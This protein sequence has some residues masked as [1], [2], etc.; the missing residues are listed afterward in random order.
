MAKDSTKRYYWL[1]LKENFFEDDTIQFIEEQ[2][3]GKDYVIF[4]LKLCLKSLTKNGKLF[5]LVGNKIIPYDVKSLAKLTNTNIDTVN[6][7]MN[8]FKELG[9]VDVLD[10]GELYISQIN[11]LI[12][13]ETNKA[14]LMREKRAREHLKIE[15]GNN[16]TEMLPHIEKEKDIELKKDIEYIYEKFQEICTSLP[17]PK[18]LTDTRNK[19]IKSRLKEYGKDTIIEVFQKTNNSDFLSGRNSEWIASFDWIM[20]PSN[21]VKI[22][23]DNYV[24]KSK[25]KN[26]MPTSK[27]YQAQ[28]TEEER[29]MYNE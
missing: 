28:I 4:Y 24:N 17:K 2:E 18:K 27:D 6:T 23:E 14:Q 29:R 19:A 12:G 3:N 15:S 16:V 9:I 8:L 7:A 20:K 25:P 11:E 5:R 13:S 26:N 22:L 1:K 21:F 10:G